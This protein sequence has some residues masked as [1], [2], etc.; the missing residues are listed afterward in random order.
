MNLKYQCHRK[1]Y[2]KNCRTTTLKGDEWVVEQCFSTIKEKW[3]MAMT[4]AQTV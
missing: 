3:Q 2:I 1:C 4:D